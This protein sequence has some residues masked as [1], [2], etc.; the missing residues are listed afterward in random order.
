MRNILR[1]LE[2][3]QPLEEKEYEELMEYARKL[4]LD[5]PES[6]GLFY[7]QYEDYLLKDYATYLP[8]FAVGKDDFLDYL[9]SR[10]ELIITLQSSSLPISDFP[11]EFHPYLLHTFNNQAITRSVLP[12]IDFLI[13]NSD[14]INELPR[15]RTAEVVYKYE[16]ANPYKEL[17]LKTHFERIGRYSFV[18]R[19]QSYRYLTRNKAREDKIEVA[20]PDRLG[21]I[22]TNKQKSIY[23]YIYLT[24]KNETKAQNASRLLNSILDSR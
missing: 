13:R 10:P 18:T 11:G 21:G 6:Y 7:D 5:S 23:Y 22:F 12:I 2:R 20:G 17:G 14:L 1:K 9:L 16:E 24:E 19:L 8:R 4:R 3:R 15:P